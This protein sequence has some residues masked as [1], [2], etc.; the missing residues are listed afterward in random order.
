M[1]YVLHYCIDKGNFQ[2]KDNAKYAENNVENTTGAKALIEFCLLHR[3]VAGP[4]CID[5]LYTTIHR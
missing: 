4:V 1:E 3:D 2:R 5:F